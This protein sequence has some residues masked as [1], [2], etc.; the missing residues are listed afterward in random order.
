MQRWIGP[1]AELSPSALHSN[2]LA[3]GA[4]VPQ[5]TEQSSVP[6]DAVPPSA[7]LSRRSR[8]L[9]GS[10]LVLLLI[11]ALGLL[12]F[13]EV[14]LPRAEEQR[15]RLEAALERATGVPTEI[16]TLRAWWPG[17]RVRVMAEGVVLGPP[18]AEDVLRLP[19]IEAELKWS[20]LWRGAP[21]FERIELYE[22]ELNVVREADGGIR[23]AGM[24]LGGGS[25]TNEQ[26]SE[27][28]LQQGGAVVADA[29]LT[30]QDR[31]RNAA[32]LEFDEVNFQVRR[33]GGRFRF[34]LDAEAVNPVASA[35]SMEGDVVSSAP[36][37]LAHWDG[38]IK[39]DLADARLD[40][41]TPWIDYPIPLTGHGDV[42]AQATLRDS[43]V[44]TLEM[45]FALE[46]FG[47]QFLPE[48]PVL[49]AQRARGRLHSVDRNGQY[50]FEFFDFEVL[51]R[52]GEHLA[53]TDLTL[54]LTGEE[55][56]HTAGLVRVERFDLDAV[57]G[58]AA[59]FPF[60]E[61]VAERLVEMSP[62]GRVEGLELGWEE[63]GGQVRP[64]HLAARFDQL[65]LQPTGLWPGGEGISGA[66]ESDMNGG[67]FDV[68]VA[69]G[70]LELPAVF[71]E[72]R[73]ELNRLVAEGG[74][75]RE[76]NGEPVIW[77][78]EANFSN[79]DAAGVAHGE[80]RPDVGR[81]GEID[82]HARLMR[83][84]GAAVWRYLPWVVGEG[85]RTWV[86]RG[87]LSGTAHE[88]ALELQG[89]LEDFPFAEGSGTFRV[90]AEVEDVQLNYAPDWPVIEDIHGSLLFDGARMRIEGRTGHI[91]GVK[92]ANASAEVPDLSLAG[93][94]VMTVQGSAQGPTA[95]FLQYISQSP[96]RE[97][98][99][100]FTDG[101]TAEG[102]GD[103]ELKLEMP[104]HEVSETALEGRYRFGENRVTVLEWL[105]P[106]ERAS[107]QVEFTEESFRIEKGRGLLFGQPLHLAAD[108]R[109]PGRVHFEL[110]GGASISALRQFYDLPLMEHLSGTT[111]WNAQIDTGDG[112]VH[113]AVRSTLAGISSS[114]PQPLNKRAAAALPFAL[115]ARFAGQERQISGSLGE[116]VRAVLTGHSSERGFELIR[117]GVG[118]GTAPPQ[119]KAG[120][121]FAGQF[122]R[123]D[124]DVWRRLLEGNEGADSMLSSVEIDVTQLHAFGQDVGRLALAASS[125][126]DGWSGQVDSDAARG[127]FVWDGREK[128][129]VHL[130]LEH[131]VINERD[132]K[133]VKGIERA[134]DPEQATSLP[135]LNIEA[136]R[137]TLRGMDL[138]KL[139][140]RAANDGAGWQLESLTLE[141]EDGSLSGSGRWRPSRSHT[142]VN[143][144]I[145]SGNAGGLLTRLGY[146]EAVRG[147][148]V[149]I[150]GQLS[151]SGTPSRMDFPSLNG[152]F[153]L[154]AQNGRFAQ[155]EPGVGRLLGVLSLQSLPRRLRL[156][157]SDVFS[158]GFAFD[159]IAGDVAVNQGTLSSEN[160]EVT[161][162][163]AHIWMYGTADINQETQD[164]TVVVQPTLSESVAA[165]AAVGLLNPA[166][167]VI[168]Y[169]AQK[170]LR[171]PIERMFAYGYRIR[172]GWADP[173]VERLPVGQGA[174]DDE[175]EGTVLP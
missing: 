116:D 134:L 15:E 68:V 119:P 175:Y 31:T 94:Q 8:F 64:V 29:R 117:G 105:P 115:D 154:N 70:A 13:R 60:P 63:E 91:F 162:P 103:L 10:A 130:R 45:D 40:G 133:K 18:Q 128:G 65:A 109:A 174:A 104:L 85:T 17:L 138:G 72:A 111:Q 69:G 20:S 25:S 76:E 52:D 24:R 35:F 2:H 143:A 161:G 43:H 102:E 127:N 112:A 123:L 79:A 90:T 75:R 135:D 96:I 131:L 136:E 54:E 6:S 56:P 1:R 67:R 147:G 88:A 120:L 61:D 113:V 38:Q 55:K 11:V 46:D 125:G 169:L 4:R 172:G 114:L 27:W 89:G 160:L 80:Y 165:G 95:D 97:I 59:Y 129:A 83:A 150:S 98:T 62:R 32:S 34:N 141:S 149:D 158:N 12:A 92:L 48:L 163:A 121:G 21:H 140:V 9:W 74:W 53:P 37:T 124:L 157:F 118:V 82:L 33:V 168:A 22:P 16:G 167:G 110:N 164:L 44:E 66:I 137:F 58:L 73:V 93:Q 142:S 42:T 139:S 146:P 41:L 144:R 3:R 152:S 126:T 47:F 173:Q 156:D 50:R 36:R 7:R 108:T 151:W 99:N 101:M 106:L 81:Y 19:R 84:D 122:E 170:V 155:L 132:D 26:L 57:T 166:A 14:V 30:W 148:E 86:Q 107:G 78:D 51:T 87:V 49:D 171:D 5:M 23:I 145:V 71:P 77:L 100:G 28:L 39:V 159:R 153:V